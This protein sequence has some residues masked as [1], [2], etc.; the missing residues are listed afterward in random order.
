MGQDPRLTRKQG[1]KGKKGSQLGTRRVARKRNENE[2]DETTVS[3]C[4]A[5]Q[6]RESA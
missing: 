4:N 5:K 2:L 3:V 6:N 1:R